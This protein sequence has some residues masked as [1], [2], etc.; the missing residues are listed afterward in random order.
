MTDFNR[1]AMPTFAPCADYV[2]GPAD[3]L[4]TFWDNVEKR[5]IFQ[6]NENIDVKG[7]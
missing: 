6:L 2:F 4:D 5:L 3:Y 7:V 1:F